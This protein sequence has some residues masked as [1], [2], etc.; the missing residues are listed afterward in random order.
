MTEPEAKPVLR[1][2]EA[3]PL[4]YLIIPVFGLILV[5]VV[6]LWFNQKKDETSKKFFPVTGK[7]TMNNQPLEGYFQINFHPGE[8]S[9]N[10]IASAII[11]PDGTYEL[12]SGRAGIVGA[13]PGEYKVCVVM[14][15]GPEESFRI[16]PPDPNLIKIN[17]KDGGTVVP[18]DPDPPFEK[19]FS[20]I[21]KTP[22]RAVVGELDNRID[23]DLPPPGAKQ[24]A[25][26]RKAAKEKKK[27]KSGSGHSLNHEQQN[28]EQQKGF[29][30]EKSSGT[31]DS[32]QNTDETNPDEK[33]PL[34]KKDSAS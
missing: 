29:S 34:Q 2:D 5:A 3:D 31:S 12:T 4:G 13:M 15:E 14:L 8:E 20:S 27:K 23:I 10:P 21:K 19:S 30:S 7:V 25:A 1:K 32:P 33:V 6:F 18:P 17:P 22:Q 11:Q 26:M 9:S 16:Q 24:L 28:H